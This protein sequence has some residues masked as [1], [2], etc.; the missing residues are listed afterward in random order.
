MEIYYR[1]GKKH[2]NINTNNR[3]YIIQ[4][5]EKRT[6]LNFIRPCK[7]IEKWSSSLFFSRWNAEFFFVKDIMYKLYCRE[8]VVLLTTSGI[9]IYIERERYI[10]T[11][12]YTHIHIN[13][14]AYMY[15]Y[16]RMYIYIHTRIHIYTH[17]YKIYNT[18]ICIRV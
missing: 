18:H 13:I 1:K 3:E 11:H 4:I 9:L 16:T 5:I 7:S 17:I 14:Q 8:I 12:M 15:T 6:H 2:T 10:H